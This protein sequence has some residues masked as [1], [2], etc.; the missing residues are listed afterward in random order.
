LSSSQLLSDFEG[1]PNRINELGLTNYADGARKPVFANHK[2]RH[3]GLR[4]GIGRRFQAIL[5]KITSP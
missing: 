1:L 5:L 3:H 2:L 4:D